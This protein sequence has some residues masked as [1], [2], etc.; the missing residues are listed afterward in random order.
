MED[1]DA[2][3]VRPGS[4]DQILRDLEWLGLDWDGPV[5]LQSTRAEAHRAGIAALERAGL[6]YPCVCTRKEIELAPSAPHENDGTLR[7][8][9]TCRA[10][11]AS[12]EAALRETGRAPALRMRVPEGAVSFHDELFGAQSFA[13]A[14]Q[15]GDFPITTRDGTPS[16]QLAVVLDDAAQGVTEV[17]RGADLLPS[18]ARQILLQRALALP[19]PRWWHLPLVVDATGERLAKRSDSV[20]LAALRARDIDPRQITAWAARSCGLE[21]PSR[22]TPSDLLAAFAMARIPLSAAPLPPELAPSSPSP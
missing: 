19:S 7:Y 1:L 13:V 8:P 4:A 5:L 21:S 2:G 10:R 22:P 16:Y 18:T 11:F 15:V 14:T 6:V 3:R 17:V 20:S 12:R 9:G